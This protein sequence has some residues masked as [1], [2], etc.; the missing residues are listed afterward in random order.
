MNREHSILG[1]KN[2]YKIFFYSVMALSLALFL[3]VSVATSGA[4][5]KNVLFKDNTDSFMDHFNSV[6][7]NII[8][9]YENKV[10][11][12]P[13]ASL[14]YKVCLQI[15]PEESISPLVSDPTEKAQ[16]RY[17]K[18]DQGFVFQ[19][20]MFC[21]ISLFLFLIATEVLKKGGK[22]EKVCFMLLYTLSS[23]FL[24][25]AERGNNIILPLA[26]S[27]FFIAFYDSKNK[28]LRELAL[29]SLA[30]AVGYKI[31]PVAFGVLLLRNKQYKELFRAGIYCLVALILPFFL[32]YDGINSLTMM[33]TNIVGFGDKRSSAGNLESQLDFKRLFYFLYGGSRKFTGITISPDLVD[34]Y[35]NL[36]KYLCTGICLIGAFFI[37]KRWKVVMLCSAIIYGFSGACST[38]FLLFMMLAIILFLDEETEYNLFNWLYLI[39]LVLTQINIP[40]TQGDWTRYWPTK[41]TSVAVVGLVFLVFVEMVISVII[42]NNN[43]R[44]EGTGFVRACV[45]RFMEFCPDAWIEKYNQKKLLKA[46][47]NTEDNGEVCVN[48]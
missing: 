1:K 21:I 12:P 22:Y 8:D 20:M 38:Y 16:S 13:L 15:I 29:I 14:T 46:K 40:F 4:S 32:F 42:W 27:M 10:I 5:F 33:L 34:L 37:K 43:R 24:F 44:A 9:P 30:L 26:F 11:Y 3:L 36:F 25:M 31:Y 6:I 18:L 7:Y 41:F 17:V 48:G 45:D 39:L 19:F 23:P 2:K 28:V 35:T 47:T